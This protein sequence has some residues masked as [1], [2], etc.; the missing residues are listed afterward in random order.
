VPIRG[1]L[2][3]H[4]QALHAQLAQNPLTRQFSVISEL[5]V[6]S[7]DGSDVQWEGKNPQQQVVFFSLQVDGHFLQTFGV[8]LLTGRGFS[9]EFKGDTANY[10]VNEAALKLMGMNAETAIGKWFDLTHKG[11]IIGVV[12]DFNFRP[13]HQQVEPLV[14]ELN[15]SGHGNLVVRAQPQATEATIAALE[16]TFHQLNPAYPFSYGFVD[17][18][19]AKHYT[20]EN[21]MGQITNI[22]ALL[23]IF[24]SC[25]GLYGLAAF[26]AERRTKEIGIRKVLGASVS[27]L[28]LLLSRDFI[29]LVLVAF[30][31]AAPISWYVMHEWLQGFAY[32]V[33]MSLWTLAFA[34]IIALL[35]ALL[36][37]SFQA[38][39]AA[40]ANPVKSL[41]NE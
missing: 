15:T 19:I 16:N 10:L 8:E 38:I 25:M 21:R 20:T 26:T 6:N 30:C 24:I 18:E 29:W 14:M 17:Q 39:K 37:V 4:S 41:R 36:T 2:G 7:T 32:R 27:G 40:L 12:K 5:P 31:I 28:S 34:G 33:E 1:E 11:N 23:A 13:L 9:A 35:I 22:F 3:E